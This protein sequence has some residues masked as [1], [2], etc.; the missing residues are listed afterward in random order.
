MLY[1]VI[2]PWSHAAFVFRMAEAMQPWAMAEIF[3]IGTAVA[4]VKIGG[5]ATIS[6]GP[7]FWAF[8]VV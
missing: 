3:I 1:E 2:T 6:L 7:A 4:L 5:L 8:C